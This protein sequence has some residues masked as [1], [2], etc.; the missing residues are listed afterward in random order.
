MDFILS[1]SLSL[2]HLRCIIQYWLWWIDFPRLHIF[3]CNKTTYISHFMH[4]LCREVV[5]LHDLS[6]S[7]ISDKDVRLTSHF[8]ACSLEESGLRSS[9]LRCI[10]QRLMVKLRCN[11]NI[12][13]LHWC[14]V[15]KYLT[16]RI[17]F[18]C[19]GIGI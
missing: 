4:V 5:Y 9:F 15:D 10:I 17:P 13:N 18:S 12:G 14:L 11:C 1:L 2:V 3:F 7:I 16:T 6:K 19:G 8:L